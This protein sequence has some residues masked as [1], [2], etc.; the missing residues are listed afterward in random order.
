MGLSQEQVLLYGSHF[1]SAF[2][3]R[4][5]QFAVPMLLMDVWQDTL[6]PSAITGFAVNGACVLL[7]THVGSMVDHSPSRL[8]AMRWSILGEA[9]CITTAAVLFIPFVTALRAGGSEDI[10]GWAIASFAGILVL[11][12]GAELTMRGGTLSLEKDWAVVLSRSLAGPEGFATKLSEINSAMRT[13]DLS[14][15]LLGPAAFGFIAQYVGSLYPADSIAGRAARIEASVAIVAVWNLM[16]VPIEYFTLRNLYGRVAAL[17]T[18][19]SGQ[20][21]EHPLCHAMGD[22][23]ASP[24]ARYTRVVLCAPS[25]AGAHGHSD[26]DFTDVEWDL[27]RKGFVVTKTS[28]PPLPHT[29]AHGYGTAGKFDSSITPH[30]HSLYFRQD[31]ATEEIVQVPRPRPGYFQTLSA[32]WGRYAAHELFPALLGFCLLWF[33]V[34]DNGTLMT[35]YLRWRGLPQGWLAVSRGVGAGMGIVGTRCFPALMRLLG[36]GERDEAL[37]QG[38]LPHAGMLSVW[39]FWLML[40]PVGVSFAVMGGHALEAWIMLGSV[41]VSRAALWMFDST[42]QQLMQERIP[43]EIRGLVSGTHTSVCNLML[44]LLGALG[45]VF[46]QP[47]QFTN[48]VVVSVANVFIAAFLYTYWYARQPGLKLHQALCCRPEKEEPRYNDL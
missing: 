17:R 5:W 22:D 14:C 2:G 29:H 31:A 9:F 41:T 40:L 23:L 8:A 19:G 13:V 11:S 10:G 44:V 1:L 37:R 25:A 47:V 45:M 35:A 28:G 21:H 18:R 32:G 15:K 27:L 12:V 33:T 7:M 42:I 34:L 38:A 4:L 48:L 39:M 46:S 43:A 36:Q 3:D 30:T 16:F 20:E 26:V 6:L 24:V